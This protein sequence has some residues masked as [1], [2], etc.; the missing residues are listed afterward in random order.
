MTRGIRRVG[1]AVTVLMLMLIAQLTYLQIVDADNL[2]NDPRN[3]RSVLRDIN[4]PRGDILTADG[5]VLARS[6]ESTDNTEFKYQREYP[7]AG[8]TAQVLG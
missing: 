1:I 8:L 3:L 2:D 7:L 4:R 6:V 5:E